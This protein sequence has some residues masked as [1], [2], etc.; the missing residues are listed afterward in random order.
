MKTELYMFKH[1]LHTQQRLE[2][3][4]VRIRQTLKMFYD[5]NVPYTANSA[6]LNRTLAFLAERKHDNIMDLAQRLANTVPPSRLLDRR[7]QPDPPRRPAQ[8]PCTSL[9]KST[10]ST[11]GTPSANHR[12]RPPPIPTHPTLTILPRLTI[13]LP[14]PTPLTAARLRALAQH[15][16]LVAL[17]PPPDDE[18]PLRDALA[19][20]ARG[21]VDLVTLPL[22]QRLGFHLRPRHFAAAAGVALEACYAPLARPLVGEAAEARRQVLGNATALVRAVGGGGGGGG[23]RGTVVI[24]SGGAGRALGCRAPADVVNLAEVWGLGRAKGVEAVGRAAGAVVGRAEARR[25]SWRGVVA[26]VSG[27]EP[28]EGRQAREEGDT[29]KGQGKRKAEGA[30]E[31]EGNEGEKKMSKRQKR[32]AA[33]EARMAKKAEAEPKT[34][35]GAAEASR[36]GL[37]R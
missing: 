3:H 18:R 14:C 26:V 13:P 21:D 25:R 20:A 22:H 31:G 32:K 12:Q 34:A 7:H 36:E 23:K 16:A 37:E 1:P 30:A 29:E 35:G 15:Y 5:L 4:T 17:A 10:P 6:E 19:T 33:H 9:P 11:L 2:T 24:S 8:R 28:P 27:G